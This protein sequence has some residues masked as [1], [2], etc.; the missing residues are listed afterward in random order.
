MRKLFSTMKKGDIIRRVLKDGTE[1]GTFY[2]VTRIDSFK[3]ILTR[4][5]GRKTEVLMI[6]RTMFKVLKC[7]RLQVPIDDMDRLLSNVNVVVYRHP[8]NKE[9]LQASHNDC[10]IVMLYDNKGRKIYIYDPII[11]RG[12]RYGNDPKIRIDGYILEKEVCKV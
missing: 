3:R 6:D 9:W 11:T 12:I 4:P 8:V 1:I 5:I 10:D 7:T 2:I